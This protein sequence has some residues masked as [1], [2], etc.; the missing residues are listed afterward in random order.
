MAATP[1]VEG[2]GYP[3]QLVDGQP[4][5]DGVHAIAKGDVLDVQLCHGTGSSVRA[6]RLSP[7]RSAAEVMMSRFP[8]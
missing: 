2:G 8:A 7:T 5:A 6:A 4:V 3:A 1:G